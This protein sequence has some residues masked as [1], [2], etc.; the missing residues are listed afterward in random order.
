MLNL[1][2]MT[3][4]H[5][6]QV[7]ILI[8]FTV[9]NI[10]LLLLMTVK[11]WLLIVAHVWFRPNML[12]WIRIFFIYYMVITKLASLTQECKLNVKQE[13]P[14]IW[15]DLVKYM[16]NLYNGWIIHHKYMDK[17]HKIA[18]DTT[19]KMDWSRHYK[20]TAIDTTDRYI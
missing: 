17:H 6:L 7:K 18:V 2:T 11:K 15:K 13:T 8:H 4:L 20:K 12:E 1:I 5:L 16:Q 19:D 14:V 3:I 9:M 10:K